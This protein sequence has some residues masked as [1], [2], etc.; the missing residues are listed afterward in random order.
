MALN[1]NLAAGVVRQA[2]AVIVSGFLKAHFREYFTQQ[3]F[4]IFH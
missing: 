4:D 3:I 2:G 1:G